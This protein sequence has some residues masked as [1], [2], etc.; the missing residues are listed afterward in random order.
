MAGW[1]WFKVGSGAIKKLNK[2]IKKSKTGSAGPK[3]IEVY[4][5]IHRTWLKK[6]FGKKDK[7]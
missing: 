2:K 4:N 3:E 5:R 6:Q 1:N 7:K